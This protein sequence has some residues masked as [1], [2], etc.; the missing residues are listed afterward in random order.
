[1]Y[2][3]LPS[4]S[5]SVSITRSLFAARWCAEVG[6]S[7]AMENDPISLCVCSEAIYRAQRYHRGCDCPALLFPRALSNA[8]LSL[9]TGPPSSPAGTNHRLE[10]RM[11]SVPFSRNST[12]PNLL[13]EPYN[14]VATIAMSY[15]FR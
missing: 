2:N 1:M 12:N 15:N 10:S 5:P 7:T 4:A 11:N 3:K 6:A 13:S 9:R 8:A 14:I